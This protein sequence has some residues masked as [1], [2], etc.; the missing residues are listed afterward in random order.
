MISASRIRE[1]TRSLPD[2]EGLL[3]LPL[4]R[5][6]GPATQGKRGQAGVVYVATFQAVLCSSLFFLLGPLF[7][8]GAS[9]VLE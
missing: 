1:N 5:G 8:Q 4:G 3:S 2:T 7:S 9:G 6:T